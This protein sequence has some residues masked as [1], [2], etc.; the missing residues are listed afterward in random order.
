MTAYLH[1]LSPFLFEIS[2]GIGLRWYGLSYL[3]GFL[4]GYWLIS[5]LAKTKR[6]P[7]LPEL[8][9]DYVFCVAIG[10]MIGGRLGYCM[11]YDT[12]L[13][14]KISS[15][16]PFW[17]VLE[18]HHGGM[19]SH[20]GIAGLIISCIYFGR[21]HKIPILALCDLSATPG[22]AGI[23]FGRLANFVNGELVGRP[24]KPDLPWSVQFPQDIL[25]WPYQE[26]ERLTGL[27][28]IA[29]KI[30]LSSDT[31]QQLITT[32]PKSSIVE[33][34][35]INIVQ[36]IQHGDFALAQTL[37]PLLTPRHPSQIYE[38]LLEGLLIFCIT[39]PLWK[40]KL[41]HGVITS[42]FLFSYALVRIIGEQYRM[43]DLHIGYQLWGLTRGQWLSVAMLLLSASFFSFKIW[44][45]KIKPD[46]K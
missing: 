45:R 18:V 38:A 7:L 14:F 34:A 22:A 25:A 3:S 12:A 46:I 23:F 8:V 20:G 4:I 37:Q 42:V 44:Q 13:L 31:W 17:G 21:K 41:P 40:K 43:P 26:P 35:L 2:D 16:F 27:A 11:F 39:F 32:S 36:R 10:V 30:G 6:T 1:T 9:S 15:S 24:C 33:N 29:S 5:Y 19:A 28:S